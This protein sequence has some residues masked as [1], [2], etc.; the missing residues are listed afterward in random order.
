M[1]WPEREGHLF[2]RA[3]PTIR[4]RHVE[5]YVFRRRGRSTQFLTLRR[6][7][8]RRI[9]PGIWQPVT[10]TRRRNERAFAAAR[11]EV[12]EETGLS[13]VRWWALETVTAYFDPAAEAFELLPLFAAEVPAGATPRLSSEHDEWAF[14]PAPV[15]ARRFVWHSQ[16]AALQAVR[17]EVLDDPAGARARECAHPARPP[18]GPMPAGRRGP[19]AVRAT[20]GARA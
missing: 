18:A 13:P 14:V 10:G 2:C 12:R 16:R 19:A 17:R 20:R 5:T 11:R 7:P 8:D 15:A 6:A 1:G 9:L 4:S 3:V